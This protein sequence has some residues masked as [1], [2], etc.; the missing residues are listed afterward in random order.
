MESILNRLLAGPQTSETSR[1]DF[2]FAIPVTRIDKASQISGD[3][4]APGSGDATIYRYTTN[5]P[6]VRFNKI[7]AARAKIKLHNM[8]HGMWLWDQVTYACHRDHYSGL[9]FAVLPVQPVVRCKPTSSINAGSTGQ[10]QVWRNGSAVSGLTISSV[11]HDWMAG[12]NNV[13]SAHECLATWF[14][15][16]QAWTITEAVCP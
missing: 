3:L 14:D 12:A 15:E 4:W 13:T 5:T 10:V 8:H 16:E 7:D 2:C 1:D 9:W 6:Q 11:R